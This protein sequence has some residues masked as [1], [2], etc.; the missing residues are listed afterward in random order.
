VKTF[1]QYF[2]ILSLV[3]TLSGKS[4]HLHVSL[5]DED[6]GVIGGHVMGDM[7]VYTTAE[8]VIGDCSDVK[9]SREFD[10][11]TG[12]DELTISKH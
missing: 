2:E 11:R 8:V 1:N 12:Y 10:Q 9:F 5:G 3:G 7:I 6:G 4:G